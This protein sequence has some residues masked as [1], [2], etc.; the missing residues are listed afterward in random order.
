MNA[1]VQAASAED[2][3]DLVELHRRLGVV[4]PSA[5]W[6]R[7]F[8]PDVPGAGPS[9]ALLSRSPRKG[10]VEAFGCFRPA[11]LR[12]AGEEIAATLAHDLVADESSDGTDAMKAVL[13]EGLRTGLLALCAAP[14]RRAFTIL[15][16]DGWHA[17]TVFSRWRLLPAKDAAPQLPGVA[18][19]NLR[20]E[21]F[22]AGLSN[23]GATSLVQ[24]DELRR[25]MANHPETG[26]LRA[27]ILPGT[28]ATHNPSAVWL[29]EAPSRS[30][31]QSEWLA[32]DLAC[33]HWT[34]G[35]T[36]L[37]EITTYLRQLGRPVHLSIAAPVLESRLASAG[38]ERLQ[39]R[40]AILWKLLDARRRDLAQELLKLERWYFTSLGLGLDRI[41]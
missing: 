35:S 12:V 15:S 14:S 8:D 36:A 18:P 5:W 20:W 17:A 26:A 1:R 10:I 41:D 13:D 24:T 28:E 3:A 23:A 27:L 2:D 31:G 32:V 16:S 34:P 4:I 19:E 11:T 21:W 7:A 33:D 38:W 40:W 25:W 30:A 9:R 6:G 37:A 39:P 29:R 22:E